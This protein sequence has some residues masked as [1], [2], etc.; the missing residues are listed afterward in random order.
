MNS[1]RRGGFLSRLGIHHI[2]EYYPAVE[3]FDLRISVRDDDAASINTVL[4][5]YSRYA[6]PMNRPPSPAPTYC[7]VDEPR[8][9]GYQTIVH[10]TRRNSAIDYQATIDEIVTRLR[11][12]LKN[13]KAWRRHNSGERSFFWALRCAP[14]SAGV[15]QDYINEIKDRVLIAH[16]W[17]VEKFC[18]IFKGQKLGDLLCRPIHTEVFPSLLY[19]I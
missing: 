4:P 19:K 18:F 15:L 6:D 8:S 16:D 9:P 7:T 3:R 13:T 17:R 11:E 2:R 12:S 14:G 1:P 5:P 10:E